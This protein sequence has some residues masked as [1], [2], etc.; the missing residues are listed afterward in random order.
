MIHAMKSK[1]PAGRGSLKAR[2]NRSELAKA[3]EDAKKGRVY[4]YGSAEELFRK[5]GI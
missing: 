4:S 3:V 5:F 1:A 2:R